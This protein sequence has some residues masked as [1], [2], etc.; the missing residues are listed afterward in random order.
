MSA[1]RT[2]SSVRDRARQRDG[3]ARAD[4]VVRARPAGRG[5]PVEMRGW[6]PAREISADRDHGRA[7]VPRR[8]DRQIARIEGG[9]PLSPDLQGAVIAL[10]NFDGFHLGHQA[11]VGRALEMARDRGAAVIVATFDPHPTRHFAPD[12]APFRLTTLAQRQGLFAAAGVAAMMVFRFDGPLAH[13]TP[14]DFVRHWLVG[15][16]GVVTGSGFRFGRERAGTGD[17]LARLATRQGMAYDAV[18][19]VARDDAVV[20]S[21][22]IRAALRDGDCETAQRLLTRPF[23]M[24]GRLYHRTPRGRQGESEVVVIGPG[25]YVQPPAGAYVARLRLSDGRSLRGVARVDPFQAEG[26][27]S[28]V[29]RL[30]VASLTDAEDGLA[31]EVDLLDRLPTSQTHVESTPLQLRVHDAAGRNRSSGS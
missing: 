9:R 15:A 30:E 31:V 21:S 29:L 24:S 14:E 28:G 16:G 26:L 23:A 8:T 10:G 27:R 5:G 6:F 4:L 1:Y 3:A 2:A 25:D 11:V 13:V 19:A 7:E 22:R 17:V 12:A 18:G 20:S